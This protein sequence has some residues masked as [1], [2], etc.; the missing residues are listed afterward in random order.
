MS[1]SPVLPHLSIEFL[2][3]LWTATVR[4]GGTMNLGEELGV[5]EVW[6]DQRMA[7][8]GPDEQRARAVITGDEAAES[9]EARAALSSGKVLSALQLHLRREEREYSVTL[10]AP[11]LDMTGVKFPSHATDGEEELLFE[12]MALYEELWSLVRGLYQRF[13]LERTALNWRQEKVAAIARW[14]LGQGE[15]SVEEDAA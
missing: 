12:R 4:E 10:K 11:L 7:F 13:A 2:I 9:R 14:A 3:W 6:V 1:E 5:I 15:L 8:R